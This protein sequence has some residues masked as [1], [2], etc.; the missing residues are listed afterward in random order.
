MKP[1][2]KI[3]WSPVELKFLE[4]NFEKYTH[5][6]LLESINIIRDTPID[7][8]ALR[9]QLYRMKLLHTIQIRWHEDDQTYLINNYRTK[10]NEELARDLNTF[11]RTNRVVDGELIFRNFTRKHVEKKMCLL[12]LKRT[13]EE[14][15]YIRRR[16]IQLGISTAISSTDNLW[17]R[18]I[19][20]AHK[21]QDIVIWEQNGE[22]RR[23]IKIDGKFIA[24]TPWMY[25]NF[26]GSIPE[27]HVVVHRDLDSLN[28][29]PENLYTRLP[30]R[31]SENEYNEALKL[32]TIREKFTL[33]EIK[34]YS[35]KDDKQ[36]MAD[37]WRIR[38]LKRKIRSKL[39][40]YEPNPESE[41]TEEYQYF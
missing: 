35:N 32:L 5:S 23:F 26:I 10:S 39:K 2:I 33:Q 30:K 38:R 8:G 21:E 7:I 22:R 34:N 6:K 16:N 41:V 1:K 11:K 18:G 24:Y 27:N 9:H 17:T 25:K 36:L 31:I 40:V 20:Q 15:T 14:Y 13:R 4:N 12:A 37:L 28:D 29:D 3:D 19:L